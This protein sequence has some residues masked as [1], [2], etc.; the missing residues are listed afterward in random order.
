[1]SEKKEHAVRK[2]KS[3]IVGDFIFEEPKSK[4]ISFKKMWKAREAYEEYAM[5]LMEAHYAFYGQLED[6]TYVTVGSILSCSLGTENITIKLPID[7]G[8]VAPNQKGILTCKDCKTGTNI[9]TFGTCRIDPTNF[10]PLFPHPTQLSNNKD[11]KYICYPLL[12]KEW[13]PKGDNHIVYIMDGGEGVFEE[14]IKDS[15]VLLCQYG[16]VIT[17]KQVDEGDDDIEEEE[18]NKKG[19]IQIAPWLFAYKGEPD[20][21][22]KNI[23]ENF[24]S[25]EKLLTEKRDRKSVV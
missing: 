20:L 9:G 3:I 13:I 25:D 22:D 12:F 1:M 11:G 23:V 17:V 21:T 14:A 8:V 18:E 2:G 24:N 7:H 16:G 6:E 19:D 15:A 4:W 5:V 10:G